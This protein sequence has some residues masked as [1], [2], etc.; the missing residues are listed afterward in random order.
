MNENKI[1]TLHTGDPEY[2][3]NF[4]NFT[5]GYEGCE[6]AL[7]MCVDR[8]TGAYPCLWLLRINILMH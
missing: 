2:D 7:S 1:I 6:E 5:R 3:I 8:S 4:W